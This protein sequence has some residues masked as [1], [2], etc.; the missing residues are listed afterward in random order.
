MGSSETTPNTATT[1][2]SHNY[3]NNNHNN[4]ANQEH[5]RGV[6]TESGSHQEQERRG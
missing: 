1:N 4:N 2:H 3:N 6:I 5:Y